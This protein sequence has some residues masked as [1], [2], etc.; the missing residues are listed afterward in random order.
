MAPKAKK[1]NYIFLALRLGV[2]TAGIGY[3]AYWITTELG[4]DKMG[5]IFKRLNP[6]VFAGTLAVFMVGHMLVGFRWWLLLRT[7]DIFIPFWAAIR[8]YFLGWFYNNFMPSSVG[9]D[10]VRAWYVT[11]HTDK[12]FEAALSVF[13][14]RIVGLASTLVIASFFYVL[15]LR[16]KGSIL[17]VTEQTGPGLLERIGEYRHIPFYIA[18]GIVAALVLLSIHPSSRA[19]LNGLW[20]FVKTLVLKMLR[21]LKDAALIYSR[22]PMALICVFGLTVAMQ[23]MTI[24]AFWLIGRDLGIEAPLKYYYVCFTLAW[25][26]GAIPVSIGGA[27]VVEGALIYLFKNLAG[28]GAEAALAL[29]LCQR[30][31]WLITS[32][33]GAMIHLIGAH[34]P[35]DL[36]SEYA[37][38][39]SSEVVDESP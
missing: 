9:G 28:V 15:F 7:Q 16:G 10:L 31:A 33:P 11:R 4:W 1:T 5:E 29:A 26:I 25:V 30:I 37:L 20:V 35:K 6:F 38:P 8:L 36:E 24:T 13:V 34:L 21:K 12:K 32:L 14:D 19:L 17:P 3:A 39:D 27:V 2:V 18:G 22:K 23:I